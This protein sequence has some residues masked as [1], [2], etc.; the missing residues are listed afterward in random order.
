MNNNS[1]PF[2][3]KN[4]DFKEPDLPFYYLISA[5]GL[6]LVKNFPLYRAS[7]KID[8]GLPW[9][10]ANT[11]QL[12][13]K[14]PKIPR[15]LIEKVVGFFYVIFRL[16]GSEAIVFL[17]YHAK[18]KSYKLSV[19]QQEVE[20]HEYQ[21]YQWNNYHLNYSPAPTPPGYIRLGTIHSHASMPAYYS[22]TDEKDSQFDD[23]LNIVVGN[24]DLST[25]SFS[26]CF[27][28]HGQKFDLYPWEVMEAYRQPHFPVP[29]NWIKKV[30]QVLVK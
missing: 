4:K 21:G 20:L 7:I 27:M 11:E 30:K 23:S 3:F 28:V 5:D 6:F 16:Y 15:R 14:F 18:E 10:E 26:A 2:F 8:K 24:L 29:G 25:P 13:L 9:L 22:W 19:P 17:Y 12:S 1:M